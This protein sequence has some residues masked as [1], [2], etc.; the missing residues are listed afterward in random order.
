MGRDLSDRYPIVQSTLDAAN[1]GM[2]GELLSVMWEGPEEKLR[3]TRFTQPALYAV[4]VAVWR[5]LNEKGV[6][7]QFVAGHSLGEYAALTAA[8]VWSFETGLALVRRR[9][10]LIQEAC[11]KHPGAMAAVL[12]LERSAVEKL[13]VESSGNGDGS[14]AVEPVNY[15][16]P[17]QLVV[18]GTVTA[19]DRL[20]ASAKSAGAAKALRLN[21]F[22]AFHSRLMRDAARA[23]AAALDAVKIEE[24]VIPVAMNATGRIARTAA[25]VRS[26]IR[27]QLDHPVRWDESIAAIVAEGATTFV[28]A[29][30]GRVLSGLVKRIHRPAA[31]VNVEDEA[32]LQKTIGACFG[33]CC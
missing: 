2:N 21:V 25:E 19:V 1:R 20:V 4:D 26:A 22:G 14:D 29:G 16:A 13:C 15:N 33:S 5:I 9:G 6:E 23:M 28:E 8:G 27:E 31:V 12:G 7:A 10:E 30:P 11:E 32:S 24:P 17:G 18:A 3:E